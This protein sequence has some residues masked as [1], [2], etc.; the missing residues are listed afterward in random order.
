MISLRVKEMHYKFGKRDIKVTL[1]KK[2][3]LILSVL[4]L[5]AVL[6][7]IYLYFHSP[8]N[9]NIYPRCIFRIL[10]KL[11]CPGCGATRAT[12]ELLHGNIILA[13]RYNPL[14]ILSIPFMIYLVL[15]L[16]DININDKPLL[17]A[18]NLNK[19]AVISIFV[20]I[21]GYWILRNINL[22]PFTLLA[23]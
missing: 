13:F 22:Y 17:P 4:G 11:Y 21:F 19:Y 10:F 6:L 15:L 2:V 20:I 8:F 7:G 1:N 14:Y 16:I 18:L 3:L 23:P 12:Y 5:S 9:K